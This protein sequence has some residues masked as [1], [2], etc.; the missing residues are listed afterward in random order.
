MGRGIFRVTLAA[1]LVLLTAAGAESATCSS[2]PANFAAW[3]PQMAAEA[4]AG[5]I[6]SR[7]LA[8]LMATSYSTGTIRVDRNQHFFHMGLS[9]FMAKRGAAGIAAIGKRK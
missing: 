4:R 6:G 5:G 3:K 8:A 1:A 9:E 7:G 2:T